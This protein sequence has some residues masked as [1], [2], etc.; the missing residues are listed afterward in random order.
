MTVFEIKIHFAAFTSQ[1][2]YAAKQTLPRIENLEQH[3]QLVNFEG[4]FYVKFRA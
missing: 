4:S 1:P 2:H 3:G